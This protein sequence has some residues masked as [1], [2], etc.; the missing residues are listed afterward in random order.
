M[1]ESNHSFIVGSMWRRHTAGSG[2]HRPGELP[3]KRPMWMDG[4]GGEG[5]QHRAEVGH[6]FQSRKQTCKIPE[7]EKKDRFLFAKASKVIKLLQWLQVINSEKSNLKILPSVLGFMEEMKWD[8]I[9]MRL[10]SV[11]VCKVYTQAASLCLSVKR[12]FPVA[13]VYKQCLPKHS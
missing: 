8:A 11:K 3:N 5:Q 13:E 4:A 7:T 9:Y 12:S 6:F 10:E 2:S 1:S